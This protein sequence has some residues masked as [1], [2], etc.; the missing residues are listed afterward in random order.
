MPA[1][2]ATTTASPSA[3]TPATSTDVVSLSAQVVDLQTQLLTLQTS[4]ENLED[5]ADMLL[6][7]IN[8]MGGQQPQTTP[9]ASSATVEMFL[10]LERRLQQ[11]QETVNLQAMVPTPC[12]SAETVEVKYLSACGGDGD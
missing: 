7:A 1:A 8:L 2:A 5:K 11:M 12:H 10:A 6:D 9:A 3:S 4:V